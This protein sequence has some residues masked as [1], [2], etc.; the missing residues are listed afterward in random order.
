MQVRVGATFVYATN[1]KLKLCS[2]RAAKGTEV[3]MIGAKLKSSQFRPKVVQ[4]YLENRKQQCLINND[5][6]A[7]DNIISGVPQ[8][9]TLERLLFLLCGND[10]PNCQRKLIYM[11]ILTFLLPSDHQTVFLKPLLWFKRYIYERLEANKTIE[12]KVH[13]YTYWIIYVKKIEAEQKNYH[14]LSRFCYCAL[15]NPCCFKYSGAIMLPVTVV[16]EFLLIR[17][18][19]SP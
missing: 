15:L 9:S 8:G 2:A 6:P 16:F 7:S 19:V 13:V 4:S 10:L 12:N 5:F 3:M 11:P 17:Q 14:P 1:N 18:R